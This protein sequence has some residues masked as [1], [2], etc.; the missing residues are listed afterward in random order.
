ML[1]SSRVADRALGQPLSLLCSAH[2]MRLSWTSSA[3]RRALLTAAA[4][5]SSTARLPA[6]A[7][8]APGV[9]ANGKVVLRPGVSAVGSEN[10]GAALYVTARPA[11]GQAGKVPPLAAAR[12]PTPLTF[13]FE[14]S[15]SSADLT[16]EFAAVDASVYAGADLQVTARFDTDGV[17]ATRGPDECAPREQ[18]T[19]LPSLS[20]MR[21]GWWLPALAQSRGPRRHQQTRRARP[22]EVERASDRGAAGSRGRRQA[23]DRW[24][25]VFFWIE[26][27]LRMW[28][29][30]RT[31]YRLPSYKQVTTAHRL[32]R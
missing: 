24:E 2:T 20:D 17:A 12:Y 27:R 18:N 29:L 26:S 13:P 10:A 9:I 6:F 31:V 21:A 11:D 28:R 3:S 30:T 22:G 15:L 5:L 25:V 1:P 19:L 16:P 23:A 14:F 32:Y 8:E 7:A 4:A